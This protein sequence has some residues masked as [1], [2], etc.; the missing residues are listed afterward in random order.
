M[1]PGPADLRSILA[2][3]RG[4][5][6][7]ENA[8]MSELTTWKVGGPARFLIKIETRDALGEALLAL[9]EDGVKAM[10]L[11]NGSNVLVSDSGFDGAVIRLR[12]ELAL[13]EVDGENLEAGGGAGLAAAVSRSAK[14]SLSGLE[15]AFGIPGTVGGAVMTNAGTFLGDIAGVVSEVEVVGLD[16]VG[17]AFT[18]SAGA[19]REP[20]V[21]V[22]SV[23]TR[24]RFKLASGD[25]SK[26]RKT[27]QDIRSRRESTQPVGEATAGSVF[28]NPA[29]MSAGKL[30]DECGFKG[31]AVGGASV[32]GVHANFIVN[33]GG[34]TAADI[35]RLMNLMAGEVEAR[36]GVRLQPEVELIGFKEL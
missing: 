35:E 12:G 18:P 19:Y 3:T 5:T 21:P 26:I 17:S 4:L 23:V 15:F 25:A 13:L 1:S 32:S 8:P 10:V 27:M 31:R 16:G 11:G 34:A 9:R 14:A 28:K 33:G 29:G 24:A 22:G 36:F 7:I 2:R 20:L 30:L 6:V